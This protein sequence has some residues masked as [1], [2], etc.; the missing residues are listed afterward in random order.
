M[1][2]RDEYTPPELIE[3]GTVTELTEKRGKGQD[4]FQQQSQASGTPPGQ[5]RF[6]RR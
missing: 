2:N 1:T 5:N 6:G 3:Y 4:M